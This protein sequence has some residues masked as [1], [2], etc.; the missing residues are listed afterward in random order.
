MKYSSAKC[1]PRIRFK[2]KILE[3]LLL[4][5]FGKEEENVRLCPAVV[6][7]LFACNHDNFNSCKGKWRIRANDVRIHDP[8]VFHANIGLTTSI[9]LFEL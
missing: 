7:G 2:K 1:N 5:Y 8:F 3:K 9:R 4:I 6:F